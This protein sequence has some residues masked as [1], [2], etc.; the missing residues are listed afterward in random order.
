MWPDK[1]V[2]LQSPPAH[3]TSSTHGAPVTEEVGGVL[4]QKIPAK[5]QGKE[6]QVNV[7]Q[8]GF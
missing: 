5:S 8:S 6:I 7:I 4:H 3:H 1:G 2:A